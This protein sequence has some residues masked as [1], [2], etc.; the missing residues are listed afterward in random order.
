MALEI[1]NIDYRSEDVWGSAKVRLVEVTFDASYAT[2]GES[3]AAGDVALAE[4]IGVT[5]IAGPAGYVISYD[6][7]NETLVVYGVQQD[8][9][10]AVTDELDE[11][12][13]AADLSGLTVR[14]LVIGR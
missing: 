9:D 4:I 8:A 1:S 7:T 2:G 14:L 13:A 11:E 12:D 5:P 10:A 6:P 3:L